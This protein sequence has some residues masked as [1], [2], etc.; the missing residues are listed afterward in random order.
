M[1][2]EIL[3]ILFDVG[4]LVLIWM[5]QLIVYPSFLYYTHE[6]LVVWHARY[7]KQISVI[8]IPLMF[9]QT[10]VSGFQLYQEPSA[11]TIGSGI[12]VLIT[13]I[14]TFYLFVPRHNAISNSTYTNKTLV[15]LVS[16]NWFRTVFWTLIFLWTLIT[17][18]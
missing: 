4:L 17:H 1:I 14:L 13:W 11:Y 15:E 9:G 18:V 3:R 5:V 6:Q 7:V 8:V 2:V 10:L 16:L 12:L